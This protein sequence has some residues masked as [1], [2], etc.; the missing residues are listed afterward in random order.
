[1]S[2]PFEIAQQALAKMK[3]EIGADATFSVDQI[4]AYADEEVPSTRRPGAVV[5]LTRK[6]YIVPTGKIRNAATE[7]RAGSKV[8]EYRFAQADDAEQAGMALEAGNLLAV[9]N[10]DC[11]A[12][13]AVGEGRVKRLLASLLAKR[14]LVLT[15]LAG[16]GK[17]KLA[18][19]FA[20]WLSHVADDPQ[21]TAHVLIPVGAD[22][23]GTDAILGY[24][25]GIDAGRYVSRAAL[26]LILRA[27]KPENSGTPHFLILDEMNLSHVERYF[28]DILSAIE[29]DEAIP[30]HQDAERKGN[31]ESVP[32]STKL[33]SNLFIIGTV[34]VDETT[35]MFS[36]KVLDRANVIEFRMEAA[37]IAAFLESPQAVRLEE[38][39]GKG[40]VFGPG[41]VALAANKR[42]TVPAEVKD[43]FK[44]EMLLFFTLL[45]KHHAEFG[46]RTS[47]EAGRFIHFYK[48]LGGHEEA[49][50]TWFEP[51][52]DAVIVQKLLPKLHGSRTKLEGLLWALA[53]ACGTPRGTQRAEDYLKACALAGEAEDDARSPDSVAKKLTVSRGQA[54]FPLSFDKILRMHQKLVRDQFVTFAEA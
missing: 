3:E 2:E 40:A 17:T 16:S 12:V 7:K 13:M 37:E 11:T 45:Q 32:Q 42:I 14:F 36:P 31:G 28:A 41:F 20:R 15:G 4:W 33:P 54:R 53:Y 52:M 26:D 24:A 49:D 1:M 38:L 9:F 47:Y 51:A 48:E 18:Q 22:W 44:E 34:N 43:R 8:P 35:Y 6:G 39:D 29:S 30:L 21:N 27:A 46:Y 19:A 23:T 25:D 50:A 10:N 5:K